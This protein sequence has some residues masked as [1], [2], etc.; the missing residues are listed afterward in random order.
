MSKAAWRVLDKLDRATKYVTATHT[1]I[2]Y[3]IAIVLGFLYYVTGGTMLESLCVG[4]SYL[5]PCLHLGQAYLEEDLE[6]LKNK[7]R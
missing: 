2:A 5:V 7:S 1:Y 4:L 6:K 3:L